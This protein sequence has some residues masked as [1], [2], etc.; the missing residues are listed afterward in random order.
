MFS[1]VFAIL[2]ARHPRL[3]A[4]VISKVTGSSAKKKQK[5]ATGVPAVPKPAPARDPKRTDGILFANLA[6]RIPDAK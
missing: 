1:K 4:Y 5:K 3:V 2:Q 6:A